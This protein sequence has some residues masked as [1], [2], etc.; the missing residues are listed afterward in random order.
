MTVATGAPAAGVAPDRYRVTVEQ[1][2]AFRRDGFV[3]VRGLVSAGEVGELRGHTE[4]LMQGRLPE[5]RG[6]E[7]GVR[8]VGKDT[9]VTGQQL[10]AP[11]AHLSPAEKAQYF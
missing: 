4:E 8:D 2:R 5:Q 9:G 6:A 11:P 1:Y 7:M 10:E 3:V